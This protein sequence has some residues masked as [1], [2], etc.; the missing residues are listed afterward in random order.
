[1]TRAR[2]SAI[3]AAVLALV[4]AGVGAAL[5]LSRGGST[6]SAQT[7]A[8]QQQFGGPANSA[9]FQLFRQCMAKNGV[10]RVA[11]QPPNRSDP[12]FQKAMQAC[13]QYAP[14]RPS[15]G[16]GGDGGFGPPQNG[17]VAPNQSGAST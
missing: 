3:A 2:K 14:A 12:T 13:A 8:R 16:A 6:S 7:P 5:L 4:L 17:S 10:T 15:G 11:G 1:M 9:A